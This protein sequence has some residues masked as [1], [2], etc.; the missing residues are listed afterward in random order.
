MKAGGAMR[1]G[2]MTELGRGD[3]REAENVSGRGT[4]TV[5]GYGVEY[6]QDW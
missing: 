1:K 6:E 3:I 5:G 4:H 2:I